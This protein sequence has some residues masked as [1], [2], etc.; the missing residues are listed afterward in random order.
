[1]NKKI[2]SLIIAFFIFAFAP[3]VAY[4]A[5]LSLSPASA[6]V[7]VNGTFDVKLLID[8]QGESTTS[9]DAV[10]FFDDSILSVVSIQEGDNGTNPFFPDIYHSVEP[11]QIY[12]V[13]AVID[14]IDT[15]T[16]TGTVATISFRGVSQGV[17]DVTFDCTPGKTSD[18]NISKS[19]K[20][21]TDIVVCSALINGRYT[22]G[23]GATTPVPTTPA[24]VAGP[25][26]TPTPTATWPVVGSAQ[27]TIGF[28]GI[29]IVLLLTGIGATVLIKS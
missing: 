21:Q 8:T 1:M 20:N 6:S 7:P 3:R 23:T 4:A 12:I 29:G 18:T 15:R 9:T 5:T 14:S 16:G 11:G 22:V 26:N 17:S 2:A 24:V 10:M 19:D 28:A 25:M 13:G 27:T